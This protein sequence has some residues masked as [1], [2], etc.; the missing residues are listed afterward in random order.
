VDDIAGTA[1][2]LASSLSSYLTG[3]TLHV[4]GGTE[5]AGGWYHHPAT[6]DYVLGPSSGTNGTVADHDADGAITS[7]P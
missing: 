4:D 1:V 3:Q 5:A 7:S 6:G 2:F